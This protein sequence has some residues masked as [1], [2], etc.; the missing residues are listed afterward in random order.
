MTDS[1]LGLFENSEVE[2]SEKLI[3]LYC[4][5]ATEHSIQKDLALWSYQCLGPNASS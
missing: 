3:S 4:Y 2:N 1:S 5:T